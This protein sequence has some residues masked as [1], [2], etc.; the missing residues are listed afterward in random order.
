MKR[1]ERSEKLIRKYG[2]TVEDETRG[3]HANEVVAFIVC[4]GS[5]LYT[6]AVPQSE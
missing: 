6:Q 3:G 1:L 5:H 2:W 4:G